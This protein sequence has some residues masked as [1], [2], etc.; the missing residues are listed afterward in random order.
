MRRPYLRS[1]IAC[2]TTSGS[3]QLHRLLFETGPAY[4]AVTRP[5]PTPV[6]SPIGDFGLHVSFAS[7]AAE[8]IF[9][10]RIGP[11]VRLLIGHRGAAEVIAEAV[12]RWSQATVADVLVFHAEHGGEQL[13]LDQVWS[14]VDLYGTR[15]GEETAG[16]C[17]W[18]SE[19]S[20]ADLHLPWDAT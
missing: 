4:V 16:R 13:H 3:D 6:G 12:A 19:H 8:F 9:T 18:Y 1:R 7:G 2:S 11:V 20:G 14:A 17:L 10:I 15:G 5:A